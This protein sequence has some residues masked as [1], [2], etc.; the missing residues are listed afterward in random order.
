MS[1]SFWLIRSESYQITKNDS[2][3]FGFVS[4]ETTSTINMFVYR[5][6]S[7]FCGKVPC[8]F[9]QYWW[10]KVSP[11]NITKN[12]C[13]QTRNVPVTSTMGTFFEHSGQVVARTIFSLVEHLWISWR[14]FKRKKIFAKKK[15]AIF[16][17]EKLK[18]KIRIFT[19]L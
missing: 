17:A 10:Q 19:F 9:T 2:P 14:I 16:S 6:V 18:M 4:F 13:R 3:V 12:F 8:F 15:F 7:C 1:H 11:T 5:F